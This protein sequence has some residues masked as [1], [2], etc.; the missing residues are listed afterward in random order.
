MIKFDRPIVLGGIMAGVII[1]HFNIPAKYFDVSTCSGLGQMGIVMFMMIVGN[2]LD[3]KKLF[4]HKT[5]M[6][7]TILNM[8]IPFVLGFVFA[9][10]LLHN[11]SWING[12]HQSFIADYSGP[13]TNTANATDPHLN[14][15]FQI[16]IGLTISMTAF[17]ILSMFLRHTNLADTRIGNI[18]LICGFVDEILFWIILGVI[19]IASQ[20]NDII[21]SFAPIDFIAYLIFIIIIAPRLLAYIVSKIKQ[22]STMLGFLIIGCFASAALAD[23]VNLHQV[24]GGFLFGLILPRNNEMINSLRKNLFLI[25]NTVLLPIYFVETGIAANIHISLNY[26]T[27]LLIITLTFIALLGKFSGAFITG[28]LMGASNTESVLLGSLLN[29]RGII[30][31]V[32]LNVGLDIGIINDKIYTILLI[33]TMLCTFF[34]TSV[35]LHLRKKLART[36][37]QG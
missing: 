3:Y 6:P 37:V 28:K 2:Q 20:K 35:S 7:L 18:A 13:S 30:E 9:G 31:I 33:M 8:L 21:T 19:L 4:I 10:F 23:S 25:I 12:P 27:L 36:K 5:Q 15:M 34:A 14:L 17:P 29:M 11:Q 22:K 26:I 32:L 16:F 24:F 1:H